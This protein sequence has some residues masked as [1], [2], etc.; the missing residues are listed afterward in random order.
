MKQSTTTET[1][2]TTVELDTA[3]HAGAR[4]YLIGATMAPTMSAIIRDLVGNVPVG[5]PRT[6]EIFRAYSRGYA[7]QAEIA[8]REGLAR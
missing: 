3:R 5:Q 8:A 1:T 6:L 2:A 4:A 7:R